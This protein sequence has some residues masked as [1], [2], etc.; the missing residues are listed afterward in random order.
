M[1]IVCGRIDKMGGRERWFEQ[2]DE[3]ETLPTLTLQDLQALAEKGQINLSVSEYETYTGV[4]VSRNYSTSRYQWRK[5]TEQL[6]GCG[7]V[8]R[9]QQPWYG[10]IKDGTWRRPYRREESLG[11]AIEVST[12]QEKTLG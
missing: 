5:F 4:Y 7:F 8:Q 11:I 10:Y 6:K 1:V 3:Q 2:K 9:G 12:E